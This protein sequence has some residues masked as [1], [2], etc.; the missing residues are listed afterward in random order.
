[1]KVTN[2]ATTDV[3]KLRNRKANIE[4]F[5]TTLE[6]NFLSMNIHTQ[7]IHLER[8]FE[9]KYSYSKNSSRNDFDP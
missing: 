3:T 2:S 1:M 5:K 7:K 4:S 8:F 9:Y 6:M